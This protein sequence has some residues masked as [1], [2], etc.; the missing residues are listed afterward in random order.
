M[1]SMNIEENDMFVIPRPIDVDRL[2]KLLV[3]QGIIN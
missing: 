1:L 2:E 3:E